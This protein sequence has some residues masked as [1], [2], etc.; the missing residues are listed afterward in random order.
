M[1]LITGMIVFIPILGLSALWIRSR[2]RNRR[3]T[4]FVKE[5]QA[6]PGTSPETAY[7]MSSEQQIELFLANYSCRCGSRP[8][9]PVRPPKPER[10]MYD[11]QRLMG[12]RLQCPS[13]KQTSDLYV[14]PLFENEGA[15]GLAD[16]STS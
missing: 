12:I 5:L 11:G 6:R 2:T 14:N 13:C 10:F 16:L 9:D 8:Y 1:V 3:R 4:Q 15:T 7:R